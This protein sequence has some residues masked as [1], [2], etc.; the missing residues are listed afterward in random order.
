MEEW[1]TATRLQERRLWNTLTCVGVVLTLVLAASI[2]VAIR[3]SD[4]Q[5]T[6]WFLVQQAVLLALSSGGTVVAIRRWRA[7]V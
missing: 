6:V 2:L 1:K 4:D 7:H 5:P 3:Y